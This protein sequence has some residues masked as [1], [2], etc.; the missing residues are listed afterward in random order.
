MDEKVREVVYLIVEQ[1]K[2][3]VDGNEDAL[4]EL[5]Q[6]LDSGRHEADVVGEAFEMIF[7]ALEPYSREAFTPLDDPKRP[8]VRVPTGSEQALLSAPAY[9]YLFRLSKS[10][11]VTPEQF[12]EIMDSA[13]PWAAS[14]RAALGWPQKSMHTGRPRRPKSV[15]S[16]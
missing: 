16:T 11:R 12:E 7:R 14:C 10:G 1:L 13:A 6:I 3:F 2:S 9:R 15:S 8:S 5:T 4:L